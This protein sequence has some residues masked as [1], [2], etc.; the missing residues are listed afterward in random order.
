LREYVD[1]F[2]WNYQEMAGLSHDLVEHWLPIKAGFSPF[3]Q[4]ARCYNPLMYDQI[5]EEIDRLLK[6]NF[7]RLCSYAECISNIVPVEKKWSDKIRVCI[8]F[9]NLNK[10]IPKDEYPMPIDDMLINNA[11]GHKVLS[12]L[13]GDTRRVASE[14]RLNH[15]GTRGSPQMGLRTTRRVALSF[16]YVQSDSKENCIYLRQDTNLK[17]LEKTCG[18]A[19]NLLFAFIGCTCLWPTYKYVGLLENF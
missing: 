14:G 9:R 5:K 15:G 3:K 16:P 10:T 11:S 6:A 19:L 7:I 1:C 12:F 4:H 8:D 17:V 13:D 2:A 18:A